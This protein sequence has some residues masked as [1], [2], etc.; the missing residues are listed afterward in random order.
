[1]YGTT[2]GIFS[3]GSLIGARLEHLGRGNGIGAQGNQF[4]GF[5]VT[6]SDILDQGGTDATPLSIDDTNLFQV[7]NGSASNKKGHENRAF[8]AS[9][10]MARSK[11]LIFCECRGAFL[12]HHSKKF[13]Y[14]Q[15]GAIVNGNND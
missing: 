15:P 12:A 3:R 4:Q 11:S 10:F 2:D 9:T 7:K 14:I 1:M 8:T 13:T 5:A 6:H